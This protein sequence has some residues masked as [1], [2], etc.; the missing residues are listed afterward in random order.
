MTHPI[1]RGW[2]SEISS[3]SVRDRIVI[4]E[5]RDSNYPERGD[6]PLAI[7]LSTMLGAND[8]L[9]L[10][11]RSFTVTLTAKPD[12]KKNCWVVIDHTGHRPSWELGFEDFPTIMS[13]ESR[14]VEIA[15]KININALPVGL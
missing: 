10:R 9:L 2:L 6:V 13:V 7:H 8:T 1:V 5:I 15:E 11:C 3:T 4:S 12:F 14:M